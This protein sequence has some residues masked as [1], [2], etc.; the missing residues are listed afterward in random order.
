MEDLAFI[1][2]TIQTNWADEIE[3]IK[4][5][6]VEKVIEDTYH[7]KPLEESIIAKDEIATPFD[8][9]MIIKLIGLSVSVL[10]FGLKLWDRNKEA[11]NR[12]SL[13]DAIKDEFANHPQ[14][15]VLPQED[16]DKIVD[17]IVK[18]A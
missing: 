8:Y 1:K 16:L 12:K 7:E 9:D 4:W 10:G 18:K 11:R 5:A 14:I 17:S 3:L 2:E 6:N 15:K 13:E